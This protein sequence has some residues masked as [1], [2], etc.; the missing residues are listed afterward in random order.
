MKEWMQAVPMDGSFA[1]ALHSLALAGLRRYWG[2]W[3]FSEVDA[4]TGWTLTIYWDRKADSWFKDQKMYFIQKP[5]GTVLF[6]SGI[7]VFAD[8]KLDLVIVLRKG[9]ESG[10]FASDEGARYFLLVWTWYFCNREAY[11][12]MDLAE[13]RRKRQLIEDTALELYGVTIV[14][15]GRQEPASIGLGGDSQVQPEEEEMDLS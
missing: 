3:S 4:T 8:D 12:A 7:H 2:I 5:D 11:M 6:N 13:E 14:P 10:G 9:D 15:S 1:T